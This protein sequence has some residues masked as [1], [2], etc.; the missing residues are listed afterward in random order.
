MPFQVSLFPFLRLILAPEGGMLSTMSS[1]LTQNFLTNQSRI[2]LVFSLPALLPLPAPCRNEQE[3]EQASGSHAW[4]I[5]NLK[6]VISGCHNEEI[7]N[8]LPNAMTQQTGR[9]VL[10]RI[11]VSAYWL[12]K[13]DE[14]PI[15]LVRS[16]MSVLQ[17]SNNSTLQNVFMQL[18]YSIKSHR[19][20]ILLRCTALLSGYLDIPV[21]VALANTN[22]YCTSKPAIFFSP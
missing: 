19:F 7:K 5:I 17:C 18:L 9:A 15:I 21:E 20:L 12:R 8:R 6:C 11:T 3:Q 14:H 13:R 1:K 10:K 4:E 2:P 22:T 16:W